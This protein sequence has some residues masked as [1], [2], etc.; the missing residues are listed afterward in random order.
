MPLYGIRPRLGE[1]AVKGGHRPAERTLEG[2]FG[3]PKSTAG[4]R[5]MSVPKTIVAMLAAHLEQQ[6]LTSD[7]GESLVFTDEF[8]ARSATRTGGGPSGSPP[9][10]PAAAREPGSMTSGG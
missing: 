6:G 1:A 5:T 3:P 10:R 2:F 9:P 7:D 4:R 8:G